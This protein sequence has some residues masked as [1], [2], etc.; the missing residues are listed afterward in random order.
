MSPIQSIYSLYRKL[1]RIGLIAL[2]GRPAALDGRRASLAMSSVVFLSDLV[3]RPSLAPP[4]P[5]SAAVLSYVT[6][7]TAKA[8]FTVSFGLDILAYK[9]FLVSAFNPVTEIS[10]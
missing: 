3:G 10:I 6:G 1:S 2:S 5:L 8:E 9:K 7:G 4:E